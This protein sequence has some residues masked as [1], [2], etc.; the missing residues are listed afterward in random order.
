[1]KKSNSFRFEKDQRQYW[2]TLTIVL[3]LGAVFALGLLVYNNPVAV[4]SPSFWPVVQRR[5]NAVIAMAIVAL[6]QSLAT[7]TFQ[8]VTS[9]RIITPSILGF[10]SLYT[11][12]QTAVMFFFGS[13]AL[14]AFTGV[15]PFLLQVGL[16]ILLSLLL[17][18]WLLTGK[19][20]DL[21]L[22]LLIGLIIGSGLRSLSAFMRRLLSPSEFDLLQ[23]R[24]FA[25]VNHADPGYFGISIVLIMLAA[26]LLFWYARRL[27]VL[28]L[29]KDVALSLG[30]HHRR[31][32]IFMLVLVSVLMSVSTALVG[33]MTFFGFLVAT[34]TYRL[35]PTYD[36]RY[37]FPMAIGLGFLV[38]T[39]SYF[40]MYHVFNAQGVV[41]ILIEF[42]GGLTFL[43]T[44]FRRGE[45]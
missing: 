16:M 24:L 8:S 33:P 39:G 30:V 13:R 2:V 19:Y 15:G 20:G 37:Y 9:N 36:H 17:Y 34:F 7:V 41:S 11:A 31:G 35:V 21:Q 12:I 44:M 3:V 45:E 1:M 26:L 43:F 10:E 23:A 22:M 42:V 38:M 27:N 6:A 25:S 28:N 40:L 14:L 18:G 5:I 29:G 4:T 32:T